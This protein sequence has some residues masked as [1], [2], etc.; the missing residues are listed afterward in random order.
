MAER[1]DTEKDQEPQGE[2][3]PISEEQMR[4]LEGATAAGWEEWPKKK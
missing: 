3:A 4:Y 2:L 1:I